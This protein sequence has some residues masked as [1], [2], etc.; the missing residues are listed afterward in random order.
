MKKLLITFVLVIF[1]FV[2][3]AWSDSEV[4]R[5]YYWNDQLKSVVKYVNGKEHGSAVRYFKNGQVKQKEYW[6]KGCEEGTW[7]TYYKNGH[8]RAI[9]VFS[10]GVVIKYSVFNKK[11]NVTKSEDF[12][13]MRDRLVELQGCR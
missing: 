10:R 5:K 1:G 3:N 6:I 4:K 8:L 2:T 13:H 12:R 7:H 11:G 9:N